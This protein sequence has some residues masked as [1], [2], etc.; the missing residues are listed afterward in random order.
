MITQNQQ[1]TKSPRR[2]KAQTITAGTKS[3]LG[4]AA[5]SASCKKLGKAELSSPKGEVSFFSQQLQCTELEVFRA[6]SSVCPLPASSSY[7]MYSRLPGRVSNLPGIIWRGLSSYVPW[8]R[9]KAEP[10]HGVGYWVCRSGKYLRLGLTAIL[11]HLFL[12]NIHLCYDT[13][14]L[15]AVK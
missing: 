10:G 1:H 5:A 7:V 9:W 15:P 2:K 13:E 11:K 4:S 8:Y 3:A 12:I 6:T 14:V